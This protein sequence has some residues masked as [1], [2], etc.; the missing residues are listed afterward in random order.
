MQ[1]ESTNLVKLGIMV[2]VVNFSL[3][4]QVVEQGRKSG[5][6]GVAQ[7]ARIDHDKR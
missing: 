7:D 1:A 4:P 3:L 5:D 6:I 2:S